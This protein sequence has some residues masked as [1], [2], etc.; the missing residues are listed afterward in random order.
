MST[1]VPRVLGGLVVVVAA[2]ALV[3]GYPSVYPTGTTI[4][5]PG[6]TWSEHGVRHARPAGHRGRRHERALR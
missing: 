1:G 4:Y 5:E 2:H 6:K 3:L